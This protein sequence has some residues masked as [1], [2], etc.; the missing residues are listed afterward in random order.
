MII[1]GLS[2]G[3]LT[4][5]DM[6]FL[7]SLETDAKNNINPSNIPSIRARQ[8][9]STRLAPTG[10]VYTEYDFLTTWNGS[11]TSQ[12]YSDNNDYRHTTD[13]L[14]IDSKFR[15]LPSRNKWNNGRLTCT[16]P[17]KGFTNLNKMIV[18]ID[19]TNLYEIIRTGLKVTPSKIVYNSNNGSN[20]T[21]E[22]AKDA[23]WD[24]LVFDIVAGTANNTSYPSYRYD[25]DYHLATP[26]SSSDSGAYLAETVYDNEARVYDGLKA[27]ANPYVG[28]TEIGLTANSI[29]IAIPYKVVIDK[30]FD[31]I[32][33]S[34][35]RYNTSTGGTNYKYVSPKD[36]SVLCSGWPYLRG[37][38]S[39]NSV[40]LNTTSNSN[41]NI[42]FNP[43]C[44]GMLNYQVIEFY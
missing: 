4:K 44:D 26:V 15:T 1:S 20:T 37:F 41:L 21:Y 24:D 34:S 25:S 16:I 13:T 28:S 35:V 27:S 42:T 14:I 39:S 30:L 3:G 9:G 18:L 6:D 31:P 43:S 11:S 36:S 32:I 33:L 10:N 2:S 19:T 17:L 5:S 8:M 12:S 40:T 29:E 22:L 38:I 23:Y 7:Q